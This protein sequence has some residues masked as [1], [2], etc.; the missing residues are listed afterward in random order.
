MLIRHFGAETQ[1][2]QSSDSQSDSDL[3][4][5]RNYCDVFIILIIDLCCQLRRTKFLKTWF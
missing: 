5:I 4:S 1:G 3:D 2:F